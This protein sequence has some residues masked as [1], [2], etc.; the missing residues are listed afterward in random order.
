MDNGVIELIKKKISDYKEELKDHLAGGG[1]SDHSAY[2]RLVGRHEA[3]NLLEADLDEIEK[4]F[5]EG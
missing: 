3:L 4:R 2:M 5:I 1:V